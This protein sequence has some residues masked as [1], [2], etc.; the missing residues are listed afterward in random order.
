M[1]RYVDVRCLL[2]IAALPCVI[3]AALAPPAVSGE[4]PSLPAFPGAEG[5]GAVATG[6][7]GGRVIKVTNLNPDGPGSL[8]WACNQ[9][10]PRI[11]VFAVSGVIQPPNRSSE[12]RWLSI[13]EGN[14]TIAGQ[15]A[16][17]AGITIEGMLSVSR[18]ARGTDPKNV[19]DVI[20]RFLRLR[21]TCGRG[22]LRT[23]ET[24]SARR[25]IADHVSGSWSLD[26]C[27]NAGGDAE[28]ITFQWCGIEES[29]IGLEGS[30]PHAFGLFGSYNDV[31]NVSVHHCI[32]AHHMGRAPDFDQCYR[33][34]F[35]N[36]L[37]YNLGYD[38]TVIRF[39]NR[40]KNP[41]L[42]SPSVNLVGNTWRCGPG[43]MMGI[44]AY[45]PP[46]VVSRQG[47]VPDHKT[48]RHFFDGNRFD[49][50]GI[51]G[52]EQYSGRRAA[53]AAEQPF[54][55]PPVKTQT[56]DEASEL[57]L[58]S[59]GCLPRD[60]VSARTVAEARTR[61]GG[62]GR[63]GPDG[64]LMAGLEAG[65]APPDADDDGMPD[66]WERSVGLNPNDPSDAVRKVPAGGSPGDRHKGYTY[67]E[68]YINDCA[69][70]LV[71]EAQT[72]ARLDRSPPKPW[73]QPA[74]TLS[75]DASPYKTPEEM[76]RAVLEQAGGSGGKGPRLTPGW[77]AVQQLG[78]LG[79]KAASAVP[80]LVK[81]LD[82]G[83]D[84]P[85][86]VSFAAWALGAI[87][88]PAR[89][90]VPDLIRALKSEQSTKSGKMN[91]RTYGFLAWA[92]GRIGMSQ[93]QGREAAPVL[94]KLLSCVDSN[95]Q[96]SA[97]W[98]LS[99]MGRA[100]EP[101]MGDLLSALGD[102]RYG[103]GYCAARAL[104]NIGAPA[105]PG[106]TKTVAGSDATAQ[107][108]AARALG[109][110]GGAARAAAPTLA[111][112]LAKGRS[113]PARGRV[114]LALAEVA[115]ESGETVAA[116]AAAL[117]D[118]HL[119][120]RV[121]AAMA[122]RTCGPAARGAAAA[123]EKALADERREVRRA[124]ALALGGIGKAALPALKRAL[125]GD[126]PL[127]RKYAARAV[128]DAGA[129]DAGAVDALAA[130]LADGNADVR[131]EAVWS[132]TLLGPAA[133]SAAGALE[134]AAKKDGDYVVRYAAD[135]GQAALRGRQR[136]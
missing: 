117:R 97:A 121:S 100:A 105:V 81:N 29:D 110:M 80:L 128:G 58:A 35:R 89:A 17:G 60:A 73:G 127:V 65:K 44:R 74:T 27:F 20:L 19:P 28:E 106:L 102:E 39:Y 108:H 76:A 109:W 136:R 69:D 45:M 8:Q 52:R 122:L 92:L 120:V 12:G 68:Y 50:E 99:R 134:R 38:E 75:P 96:P 15:T 13:K 5:F 41:A 61:T 11:I 32:L 115:P 101:A 126:D 66:E 48:Y 26:Q 118:P 10:G 1:E 135:V 79:E 47:F 40:S 116:L 56:A 55:M 72:K 83:A 7:R 37:L 16:P 57:V 30:Q 131:R 77:Q 22:N 49:W 14:V 85:R 18:G 82:R 113:V 111:A 78:R 34:D 133:A 130:A 2:R 119:E 64:G 104:A 87:G 124:A 9:K 123:L 91:F 86:A 129:N 63:H 46:V 132:L 95:S 53:L 93:T 71:A 70:R 25:I 62:F 98:A 112:Q 24:R 84:D 31:G 36:N 54:P 6:G 51:V 3:A 21:P 42:T 23:L 107:A 33:I 88:P 90:A 59:G 67:I 114:A 103:K 4:E 125:A 94:G 43:G